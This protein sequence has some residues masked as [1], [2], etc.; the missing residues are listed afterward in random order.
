MR[1]YRNISDAE[2]EA[3]GALREWDPLLLLDTALPAQ[4]LWV[5]QTRE[6]FDRLSRSDPRLVRRINVLE[7]RGEVIRTDFGS[8]ALMSGKNMFSPCG[9]R[10]F[11]DCYGQL[12]LLTAAARSADSRS[13]S[14][15]AAPGH[16][17]IR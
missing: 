15:P 10:R 7:I 8:Y 17:A 14:L 13:F 3:L 5:H 11:C 4:V 2:L 12:Y 6:K 1:P 16:A 9:C